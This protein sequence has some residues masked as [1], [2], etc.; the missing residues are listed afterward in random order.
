MAF[1]LNSMI[2]IGAYT[3][4]GGVNDLVIRKSVNQI[5]SNAVLKIPGVGAIQ[6]LS[7]TLANG[8]SII[9]IG[10]QQPVK[11]LPFSSVQTAKLFKEGDPVYI[12][13]GYNGD[14]RNE[15]RGFVRRVSLTTPVTIEMEGYAWQLR[16]QNIAASWKVTSVKEVLKRVIHGTGIVLS[17]DI[18]DIKL[19][20]F[21]IPNWN[22]LKVLDYLQN[23]LHLTVYFDDNILYAGLQAGRT[24]AAGA[25]QTGTL[26]EVK[27]NIGYNCVSEQ[28]DLKQR[29]ASD[30]RVRVRLEVRSKAGKRTLYEAGDAGGSVIHVR[31][32][33]SQ[34]TAYLQQL[35]EAILK[36]SKYDGYEG[37]L[38]GFLQ[39]FCQPGWK[40][41]LMDK[42]F[43][44][45]R[46]GTYFISGTEVTFG[47]SG[48][49]RKVELTYRLS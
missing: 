5:V 13:L 10:S 44:G 29:L 2:K 45:A 31:I 8:L 35:A 11:N 22:G 36:R 42:R 48:A 26:A 27:Y 17:N 41:T 40:A 18:P 4:K 24:T 3:F 43:A 25:G 39:P 38:L 49:R 1:V 15:F 20:A 21:V 47:V 14:L 6:S 19:T 37:R 30:N 32:P 33:Y 16:S 23:H 9:G 7:N 28:K 12:D 34:D 46:A